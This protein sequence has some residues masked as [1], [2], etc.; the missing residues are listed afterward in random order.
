[1]LNKLVLTAREREVAEILATSTAPYIELYPILG[2]SG[3][4]PLRNIAHLIYKKLGIN[5]RAQLTALWFD[6]VERMSEGVTLER[7]ETIRDPGTVAGSL[8][9]V[10]GVVLREKL[11]ESL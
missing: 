9:E 4:Q 6:E 11:V 3:R 5:N 8:G 1:L 2:M 7:R 10:G